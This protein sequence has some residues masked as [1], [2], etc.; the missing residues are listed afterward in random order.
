MTTFPIIHTDE[1]LDFELSELDSSSEDE[2]DTSSS[3]EEDWLEGGQHPLLQEDDEEEEEEEGVV[4]NDD[5]ADILDEPPRFLLNKGESDTENCECKKNWVQKLE[6][7]Q[8][9]REWAS[10][11]S[12]RRRLYANTKKVIIFS[13]FDVMNIGGYGP[14]LRL[15]RGFSIICL[16][17]MRKI[18][19][20]YRKNGVRKTL[21][22]DLEGTYLCQLVPAPSVVPGLACFSIA[23]KVH[24]CPSPPRG[25]ESIPSL[26]AI[27]A[28]ALMGGG[29]GYKLSTVP[30]EWENLG[31]HPVKRFFPPLFPIGINIAS[32]Q[33]DFVN[34]NFGSGVLSSCNNVEK[35]CQL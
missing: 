30:Q 27:S 11:L 33:Q 26:E 4:I 25:E 8:Y 34:S 10:Y 16:C 7:D 14:T 3:E 1:D 5:N 18:Q 2:D 6:D 17:Q 29:W 28:L 32:N 12:K 19:K 31:N 21:A 9:F 24:S 22:L 20:I 23:S 35:H 15:K 13:P